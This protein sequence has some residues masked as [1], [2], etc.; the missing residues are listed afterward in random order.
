MG[1]LDQILGMLPFGRALRGLPKDLDGEQADLTRFEAIIGSMTP[2]ERVKPAIINGSRRA[3]IAK[4]SGTQVADVNRLL[5]HYAQLKQMMKGLKQ[6]EGRMGKFK[7]AM[8]FLP[9]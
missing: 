3:R 2:D 7:G 8:P 5:K 4:G 1:P 6:M 9:R